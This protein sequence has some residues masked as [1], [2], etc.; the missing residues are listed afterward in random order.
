L[1]NTAGAIEQMYSEMSGRHRARKSSIQIVAINTLS[2]DKCMRPA[3]LQ[4]AFFE[5]CLLFSR[6]WL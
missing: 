3:T 6:G 2:A 5:F 1:G 4:Y